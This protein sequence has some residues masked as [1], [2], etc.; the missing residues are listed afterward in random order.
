MEIFL[1]YNNNDMLISNKM[2]K[3]EHAT[4]LFVRR[5]RMSKNKCIKDE[6]K[7]GK[8]DFNIRKNKLTR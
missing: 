5:N 6:L 8:N 4:F 2:K 3:Q 7:F 1:I